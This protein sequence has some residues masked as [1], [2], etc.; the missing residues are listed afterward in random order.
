[1]RDDEKLEITAGQ[2]RKLAEKYEGMK[3]VFPEVFEGNWVLVDSREIDTEA[4]PDSIGGFSIDVKYDGYS[5]V[6]I[7]ANGEITPLNPDYRLE[8]YFG[9]F[10][11][12]RKV[13]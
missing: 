5:A 4:W 11:L 2:I 10:R 12:F 8:Q 6:K 1:M 9:T 13:S 3:E 7:R